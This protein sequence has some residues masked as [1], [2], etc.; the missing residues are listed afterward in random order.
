[1]LST[2][3]PSQNVKVGPIA[4][5]YRSGKKPFGTC[6]NTC[7]LC[8]RPEEA[9]TRIDHEYMSAVYNTVPHQ[10]RVFTYVHFHHSMWANKYPAKKGKAVFNY[11]ADTLRLARASLA[12]GVPTVIAV[13]EKDLARA[14]NQPGLKIKVCPADKKKGFN[15]SNCG[16]SKGPICSWTN[17]DFAVG[18]MVHGTRKKKAADTSQPGGCYAEAG[19]YTR[20]HWNQLSKREQQKSDAQTHIDFVKSLPFATIM[21]P[22]IA[23]DMGKM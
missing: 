15:C 18:F 22:H 2:Q 9:T 10:G 11:S 7:K 21:R 4:T 17:R 1:M 12:A 13:T 3:Y 8:D 19:F 16:G 20:T 5:S 6:P 14:K 23:G